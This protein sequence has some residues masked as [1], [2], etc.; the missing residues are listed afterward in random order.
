MK[1]KKNEDDSHNQEHKSRE[2]TAENFLSPGEKFVVVND[3]KLINEMQ[4]L[5]TITTDKV[6]SKKKETEEED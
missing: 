1:D 3:K 6:V 4:E 2:I 5:F